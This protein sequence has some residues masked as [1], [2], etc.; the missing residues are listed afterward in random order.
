MRH[1]DSLSRAVLYVHKMPL[2]KE[3]EFRQIT[4]PKLR[5]ISEDLEFNDSDKFNLVNG[6]VYL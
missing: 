5:Q 1:V 4:D 3:L 2:E 6:L